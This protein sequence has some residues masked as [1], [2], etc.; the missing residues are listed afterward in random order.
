MEDDFLQQLKRL[1]LPE[2]EERMGLHESFEQLWEGCGA[3]KRRHKLQE[4]SLIREMDALG[5][6]EGASHVLEFGC[7]IATFSYHIALA[8]QKKQKEQQQAVTFHMLDRQSFRS[9]A[10]HD[11]RIR[12]LGYLTDRATCDVFGWVHKD[13]I[14]P[15][16][17]LLCCTKHFCG[18]AT[19]EMLRLFCSFCSQE[20]SRAWLV[21]GP[22]CHGLVQR[23]LLF[24]SSGQ[25]IEEVWGLPVE[26]LKKICGWATLNGLED[27]ERKEK[28]ELGRKA[29]L[30]FEVA[31]SMAL[32]ETLEK[33]EGTHS[34]VQLIRYTDQ[35]VESLAILACYSLLL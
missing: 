28:Q 3:D 23:D 29:K 33:K 9:R 35:S 10:R 4:S 24:G 30:C 25:V 18:C 15:A 2:P 13:S 6:L 31:R 14:P 20:R 5:A 17:P 19:D 12:A 26:R 21:A 34:S 1:A 16:D 27:R 32:Q 11:Y 22:C 7:G 8:K